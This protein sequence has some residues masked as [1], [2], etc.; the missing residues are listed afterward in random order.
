M[1]FNMLGQTNCLD[2]TLAYMLLVCVLCLII[3]QKE[4]EATSCVMGGVAKEL[5][6]HSNCTLSN[7][8]QCHIT[9]AFAQNIV[10]T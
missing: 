1:C 3:R 10:L 6:Y 5:C 2:S 8:V 7:H 4:W 9:S